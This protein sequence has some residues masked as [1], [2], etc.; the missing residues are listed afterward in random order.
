MTVKVFDRPRSRE[1]PDQ[2]ARPRV[3]RRPGTIAPVGYRG[4][5][6]ARPAIPDPP[7]YGMP[8]RLPGRY[9][10][11]KFLGRFASRA[12]ALIALGEIAD[13]LVFKNPNRPVP[14]AF[15]DPSRWNWRHGLNTYPGTSYASGNRWQRNGQAF[16]NYPPEGPE[17]GRIAG[18]AGNT[19]IPQGSVVPNSASRV[20]YW[21]QNGTGVPTSASRFAQQHAWENVGAGNGDMPK[22]WFDAYGPEYYTVPQGPDPNPTRGSPGQDPSPWPEPPAPD[23]APSEWGRSSDGTPPRHTSEPPPRGAREKKD[24]SRAKRFGIWAW[25]MLDTIA[26]LSEIGGSLYDALPPE[27]RERWNCAEGL[28]IGQY[29]SDIN[30]CRMDALWHNWHHLDTDAAWR[31]IAKNIVEDMTIGQFHKWLAKVT[32][33][34]FVSRTAFTHGLAQLQPEP[35]IAARLKELFEYLGI[36]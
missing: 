5:T 11:W 29:G 6:Y 27:V 34:G 32:P 10:R 16:F 31:N 24:M 28:N 14:P 1:V 36:D 22:A 23:L 21:Y 18:Q 20:G 2:G 12:A 7:R 30:A 9:Q 15:Q 3:R 25:N 19:M 26:E 4:P 33:K 35:Y 17:T 13:N 8:D